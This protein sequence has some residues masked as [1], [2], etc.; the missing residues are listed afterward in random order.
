MFPSFS[1][2]YALSV[3]VCYIFL[4]MYLITGV[5]EWMKMM[6]CEDFEDNSYKAE[7]RGKWVIFLKN[8]SS[9][10][11]IHRN[12]AF[13]SHCPSIAIL[14]KRSCFTALFFPDSFTVRNG[15]PLLPHT[16]FFHS[17]E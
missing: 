4:E 2:R 6:I 15:D 7:N 8:T 9:L 10:K 14:V 5:K 1:S 12:C 3:L 11:I 13:K 17:V 16:C